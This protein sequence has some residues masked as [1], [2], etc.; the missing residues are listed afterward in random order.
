VLVL[1][2]LCCE[3]VHSMGSCHYYY[4]YNLLQPTT[5]SFAAAV[6]VVVVVVVVVVVCVVDVFSRRCTCQFACLP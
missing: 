2:G 5:T 1:A 3:I 4:F 6:D